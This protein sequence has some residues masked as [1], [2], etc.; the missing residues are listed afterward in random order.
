MPPTNLRDL[1][2]AFLIHPGEMLND[3]LKAR[4]ITQVDFAKAIDIERSQLNE[5]I[6]GKRDFSVELC[7]LIAAALD[8]NEKVWLN[9]KQNY[10]VNKLKLDKKTQTKLAE[11]EEYA[12][13]K[14]LPEKFLKSQSV[15][16]EDRGESI[17][18]VRA[19]YKVGHL[20]HITDKVNEQRFA[21]HR[22]SEKSSV[23]VVNLITWELLIKNKAAANEVGDFDLNSSDQLIAS[24]KPIFRENK[25]TLNKCMAL[26]AEH[27][28][29]LVHLAKPEECA[30]DGIS[31]WS[32]GK[33]AIGL[34]L[35][36]KRIDNF[37]FTLMHELGHVF[38]HLPNNKEASFI[39]I[40][41]ENGSYGN[42]KEEKEANKFAQDHLIAPE[43][44]EDFRG[45]YYKTSDQHFIQ[46]AEDNGIHPAIPFGRFCFEMNQFKKRTKIDRTLG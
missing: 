1:T 41:D 12:Y 34:S 14:N 26:L 9:L 19:L 31:F 43:K 3:E 42:S 16:T 46:F 22:K 21:F 33:P 4:K 17:G 25:N 35:R 6:K 40:E 2:P 36:H 27:G 7:L 15:L 11:A 18:N 30:V 44:W 5:Y 10:E 8:M 13:I 37:A 24:I 29:K 28:I 32:E 23:S 20:S 45:K 38:L 39:D